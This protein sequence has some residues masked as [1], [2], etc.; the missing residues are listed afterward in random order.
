[1]ATKFETMHKCKIYDKYLAIRAEIGGEPIAN[2][3]IGSEKKK[4]MVNSFD[5]LV[6]AFADEGLSCGTL[7]LDVDGRTYIIENNLDLL[8]AIVASKDFSNKIPEI[9]C[10]S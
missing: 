2:L 6:E 1:M 3:K 9:M 10:Q 7:T 8:D 4:H 5:F